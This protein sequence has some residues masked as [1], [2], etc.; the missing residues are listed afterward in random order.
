MVSL[1]SM[2]V[3]FRSFH[4]FMSWVAVFVYQFWFFYQKLDKSLICVELVMAFIRHYYLEQSIF[5]FFFNII[6]F[7]K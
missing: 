2:A 7:I 6:M 5:M 3:T 1:D 4:I